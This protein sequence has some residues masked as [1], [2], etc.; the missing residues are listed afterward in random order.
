MHNK[1]G[2][3]TGQS[4]YEMIR[5]K[6]GNPINAAALAYLGDAVFELQVRLRLVRSGQYNLRGMHRAAVDTVRAGAQAQALAKLRPVLT[7]A[8]ADV[9]RMGRNAKTSVPRSASVVE[10]RL[11][12]GFEALLGYLYLRG[13]SQRLEELLDL[14]LAQGDEEDED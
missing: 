5:D 4:G 10:Y 6:Q 1:T 11:S 9:V 12:T 3:T 8:E 2:D 14:A 7:A 13:E